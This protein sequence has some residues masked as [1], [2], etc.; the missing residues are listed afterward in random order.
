MIPKVIHYCW[1]GRNKK[2][3][4]MKRCIQ[5]W[6]K[7]L[8]DYEI[9]KWTEDNFDVNQCEYSKYCYEN[10]LWA[11]LS[12]YA[13]VKVVYEHGGI[14]LDTD[15]E[16]LKKLD[17]FLEYEGFFGTE[18]EYVATGLGFGAVKG[19]ELVKRLV[20]QYE[21][22]TEQDIM[23]LGLINCPKLNTVV[24]KEFGFDIED[25]EPNETKVVQGVIL[26]GN[27][28][29]NPFDDKTGLVK[30]TDRSYTIH[31]YSKTWMKPRKKLRNRVSRIYHRIIWG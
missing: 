20:N 28:Y 10:G 9:R 21:V 22:Q 7:V 4:I 18:D 15:V 14:Y 25:L 23:K 5:S 29:L 31:W 2:T 6:K 12:D 24:F 1:F 27:E 13:R 8:P 11:Y 26:L 30:V 19:H 3:S 16:V 17:K